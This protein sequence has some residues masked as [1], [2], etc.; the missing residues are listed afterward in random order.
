[1]GSLTDASK[2]PAGYY[3]PIKTSYYHQKPCPEGKFCPAGSSV[4]QDCTPGHYCMG[5]G[6]VKETGKCMAGYFCTASAT[7]PNPT[8]GSTGARCPQG[9][10]C[11]EGA[12]KPAKCPI[13]TFNQFYGASRPDQCQVCTSTVCDTEGLSNPGSDCP[14]GKTCFDN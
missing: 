2:C 1:M 7:K 4:P 12:S 11:V 13:G 9:S 5:V 10:Y 14:A 8:D 6:N 3:C